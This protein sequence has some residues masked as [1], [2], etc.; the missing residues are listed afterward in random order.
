[1]ASHIV[2]PLALAMYPRWIQGAEIDEIF[3]F[4]VRYEMSGDV[5]LAEHADAACLTLN[6]CLGPEVDGRRNAFD[7]G[8]LPRCPLSGFDR[9]EVG[10][11]EGMN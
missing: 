6:V 8:Y 9:R 4:L 2:R 1:M 3:G 5:E 10:R 11:D 7:C